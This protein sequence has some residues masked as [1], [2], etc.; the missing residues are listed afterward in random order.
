MAPLSDT[1][2][3]HWSV[4]TGTRLTPWEY[5]VLRMVDRA[6]RSAVA[7]S[8][9]TVTVTRGGKKGGGNG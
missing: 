8:G 6:F 1:G 4:L 7:E 9:K 2:I 5:R 3:L